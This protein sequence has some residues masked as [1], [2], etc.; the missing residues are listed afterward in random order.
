MGR[1]KNRSDLGNP[2]VD[3]TC[4]SE[5]HYGPTP[6]HSVK[7]LGDIRERRVAVL[8]HGEATRNFTCNRLVPKLEIWVKPSV[9]FHVKVESDNSADGVGI[10]WQVPLVIQGLNIKVEFFSP[11]T[12]QLARDIG[13]NIVDLI[14]MDAY[15]LHKFKE[16]DEM[17]ILQGDPS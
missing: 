8:I 9:H 17:R 1:S 14:G 2:I 15:L 16:A 12:G 4:V 10:C 11:L 7:I 5:I 3:C 13:Y 6:P